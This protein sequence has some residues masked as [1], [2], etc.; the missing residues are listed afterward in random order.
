IDPSGYVLEGSMDNRLHGVTA[1]E[2]EDVDGKWKQW[3][4]EFYGQINPQITDE[5]GR[6]GWDVI[7]GNWRVI[8]SK[9]GYDTY[10]SRTVVV[11]P[12]ETQLNVPLIRNNAPVV[13]S[14]KPGFEETEVSLDSS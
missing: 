1:V 9:E 7:Q 5:D 8:F 4:A 3:N 6:Y 10:I 2:E 14:V 11:P 12:A 13:K